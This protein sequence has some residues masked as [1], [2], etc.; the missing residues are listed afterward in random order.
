MRNYQDIETRANQTLNSLDNLQQVEAG[1]YLYTKIRQ[2]MDDSANFVPGHNNNRV[3]LRLAAILI[4]FIGINCA[5]LY[6]LKHSAGNASN[7]S[8]ADAFAK[9]YNLNANTDSY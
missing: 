2:R 5:S 1:E 6:D 4:V 3:M 9:A 7:S 8:G